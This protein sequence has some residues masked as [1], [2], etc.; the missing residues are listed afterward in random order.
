VQGF[1]GDD[2]GSLIYYLIIL[3]AVASAVMGFYW[4]RG[5][6]ALR[7]A[8]LWLVVMAVVVLGYAMRFELQEAGYRMLAA[9]LPGYG[10]ETSDAAGAG[11]VIEAGSTGHFAVNAMVNGKRLVMIV[12]T[13]ASAVILTP[14]DAKAA[15]IDIRRLDYTVTVATANG[16]ARA[17]ALTLSEVGVGSIRRRNIG[18]LVTEPGKLDESLLG[19]TFLRT[20]QSFEM[21]GHRLVLRD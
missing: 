15:G 3:A 2:L 18:A 6:A 17:A 4:G 5:R 10:A 13:G 21:R 20:L 8:M 16:P 7:D 14:E 9:I 1:S 12:D 11:V 19:M